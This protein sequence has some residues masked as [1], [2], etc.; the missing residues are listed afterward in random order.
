MVWTPSAFA[1]DTRKE[2]ILVV[3]EFPPYQY[4]ENGEQKGF[5]LKLLHEASRRA[6]Y[7][8]KVIF[9]PWARV[10]KMLEDGQADFSNM[11]I[12]EER[13]EYLT[14]SDDVLFPIRI[15]FFAQNNQKKVYDGSFDSIK[16]LR[17]G[18]V[19]KI[20]Y[21]EKFDSALKEGVFSHVEIANSHENLIALL[22]GGRIDLAIGASYVLESV[23]RRN[24]LTKDIKPL[25]P[26]I[27]DANVYNAFTKT[28]DM[29]P[30]S[31]ALD[32]ALQSMRDDGSFY[33]II[34]DAF[35]S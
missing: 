19:N 8:L 20:S 27:S 13:K 25:S 24:N 9:R 28:K 12:N 3:P 2:L 1:D 11:Y 23:I 15:Q 30:V 35:N 7:E 6:G 17:I 32:R 10:L 26:P 33:D 4:T 14:F 34:Y 31:E 22:A 21:G 16:Q 5:K 29:R 18:V